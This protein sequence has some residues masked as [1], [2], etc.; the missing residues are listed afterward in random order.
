MFGNKTLDK[1]TPVPLYFQLKTLI[2]NEIKSGEYRSGDMIPT[3]NELSEIFGISRTTI[4]Q[5]ITELVREGYLYRI[6]SKGTF[7]A[8]PKLALHVSESVYTIRDDI[9]GSGYDT[10]I[11][12]LKMEVIPMPQVLIDLGAGKEGD[13]AIY[14]YRVRNLDDT[15]WNRAITYM[16][17]NK[18]PDITKDQLEKYTLRTIMDSK[19]E[20]K[21]YRWTR[22]VEA[23]SP[24]KEDMSLLNIH[25]SMPVLK[26]TTVRYNAR[27]E[28][29]DISYGFYRGDVSKIEINVKSET[30]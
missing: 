28:V 2:L 18:F 9:K 8:K 30:E 15:A 3:E 7:V 19:E 1:S 26:M 14:I 29:L 10:S 23:V 4:R 13:K 22:T 5:A 20:T 17:L 21:V 11:K 6:K 25:N 27:D 16:P 12:I 24:E